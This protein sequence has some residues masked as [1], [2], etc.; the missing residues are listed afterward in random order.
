MSKHCRGYDTQFIRRVE[1]ANPH[2]EVLRLAHMCID[3]EVPIAY[4]A[5]LFGVSRSTVYNWM[6]G[7]TV[8]RPRHIADM[9]EIV[10]RLRKR[11]K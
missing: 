8:P 6:T 9:P 4:V 10:A 7:K 1:K 5:D 3:C 2:P 11:H